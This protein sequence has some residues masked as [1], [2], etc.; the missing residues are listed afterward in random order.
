MGYIVIPRLL[1]GKESGIHPIGLS[2]LLPLQNWGL[3]NK[4][5]V[6]IAVC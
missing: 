6:E 2:S 3:F 4:E 1:T 5:E